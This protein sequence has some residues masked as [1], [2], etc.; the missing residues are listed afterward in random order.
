MLSGW[1]VFEQRN[2]EQ[3]MIKGWRNLLLWGGCAFFGGW[4]LWWASAGYPLEGPICP[5]EST[6]DNC[7][8]YNVIFYSA[9]QI[10]QFASHWSVL[11]T[12]AATVAIGYFTLTLKRSTDKLWSATNDSAKI[13]ERSL[14]EIERAFIYLEGFETEI[15]TGEDVKGME[16]DNFPK[17]YRDNP[18]LYITRFAVAP[19]WRNSGRTPPK[20]M[21]IQVNWCGPEGNVVIA[22]Y[23]NAPIPFFVGPNAIEASA[24]FEIPG[25]RAIV[26]WS[27]HPVG[28]QPL[29]LVWGRAD[30]DDIFDRHHFVEWCYKVTFSRPYLR[31]RMRAIFTQWGEYNR[32][33]NSKKD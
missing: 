13:A 33:D 20:K 26:D 14:T 10:A 30:Y 15:T 1:R 22:A 27:W 3:P 18:E 4:I 11:I 23:R 31:I 9:W 24:L 2:G 6:N 28:D 7:A 19:K 12:A 29:V 21:T 8:R 17:E 5:S 32:T 25:A 16:K